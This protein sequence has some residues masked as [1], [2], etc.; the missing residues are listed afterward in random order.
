MK[1]RLLL[2]VLCLSLW[3][4]A[5][6]GAVSVRVDGAPLTESAQARII[7]GSTYVALRA[8]VEAI[9][10]DAVVSWENGQAVV[11]AGDLELTAV[12]G[13]LYIVANGRYLFAASGVRL[14]NGRTMVPLRPLAKALGAEVGWDAATGTASLTT[15]SGTIAH[16]AAFYDEEEI[17]WLSRIISAESRG[18]PLVGMI[19]V[20]NVVLNRVAHANYPDTIYDVIFDDKWGVQFQPV[21]NG[22]IYEEPTAKSVLAA[23]LVLDGAETVREGLFFLAPHLTNNHWIMENRIYITTIGNHWF[24]K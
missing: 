11:R 15:G 21:S 22:T 2:L 24:Y 9:R 1:K 6:A 4:S 20:G 14:Q 5:A 12:P 16:A 13:E 8:V 3:L 23:K 18:E 19:A 10:P 7:N 17:Y